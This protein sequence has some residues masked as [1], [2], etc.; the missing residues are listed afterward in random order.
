MQFFSKV[1]EIVETVA[2]ALVDGLRHDVFALCQAEAELL[3]VLL[4]EEEHSL[5]FF[6]PVFFHAGLAL[7]CLRVA[8]LFVFKAVHDLLGGRELQSVES[9]IQ[10]LY[11]V[12]GDGCLEL[13]FLLLDQLGFLLALHPS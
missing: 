3:V 13:C 6:K 4:G 5:L 11:D 1:S 10:R 7:V 12:L 2:V 9:Q 8:L